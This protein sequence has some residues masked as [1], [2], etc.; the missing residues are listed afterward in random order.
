MTN[1]QKKL[2]LAIGGLTDIEVHDYLECPTRS[3]A[4]RHRDIL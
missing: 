1:E 4:S 2:H 3:L